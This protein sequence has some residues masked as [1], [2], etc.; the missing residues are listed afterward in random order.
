MQTSEK[1]YVDFRLE[2]H[3]KGGHSSRPVKDNAIYH[4][5]AGLVRL[6]AFDFPIML[7]DTTR[8]YFQKSAALET[9][10]NAAAF[11]AIVKNPGDQPA[12]TQIAKSPYSNALLRSTCV[13]TRLEGGHANN[14]LPQT[15]AA[16]VH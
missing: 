8:G 7:D 3:N 6:G 16:I 9:P 4:L 1:N 15:A 2:V 5:A 10:D 12:A 13:A 11:R 14:A